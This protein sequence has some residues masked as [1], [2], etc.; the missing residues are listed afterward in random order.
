MY[1]MISELTMADITS[2]R[3]GMSIASFGQSYDAAKG[4]VQLVD[5]SEVIYVL[6]AKVKELSDE[7]QP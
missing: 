4:Y 7:R 5:A 1:L 2:M 6:I 3:D